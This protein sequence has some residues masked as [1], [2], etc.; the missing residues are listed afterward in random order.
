MRSIS[1]IQTRSRAGRGRS[2]TW[3]STPR[4]TPQ[5]MPPKQPTVDAWP[6]RPTQPLPALLA[7]AANEH[8]LTLVHYS[9]DYVF[10]GVATEHSE[11]EPFSPLGCLRTIQG[12]RRCCRGRRRQ[13]YVI[14]TSWVIGDGKNFVRTMADLA[15]RGISPAVVDDQ[16]GRLTFTDELARA[17]RHLLDTRRPY[18]TYNVTNGGPITSWCDLARQV[19]E[20]SGRD[21]PPTSRQ[22]PRRSTA[23]E[24]TSRLAR[25]TVHCRW[26]RSGRP[27]SSLSRPNRPCAAT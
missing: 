7:H 19:F 2:T 22:P 8:R 16:V 23:K 20:L 15:A 4:R 14:R 21:P 27:G 26:P 24:R 12:S 17:T 10:D 3:C 25:S 6:G 18:G 13:H 1:R 5:S 11:D 9:T